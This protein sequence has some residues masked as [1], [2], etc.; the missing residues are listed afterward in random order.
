METLQR[1]VGVVVESMQTT[2]GPDA[3]LARPAGS[4]RVEGNPLLAALRQM[5]QSTIAERI[6]ALEKRLDERLPEEASRVTREALERLEKRVD[7][8]VTTLRHLTDEIGRRQH[9]ERTAPV[10]V[11]TLDERSTKM[12]ALTALVDELRRKKK[13]WL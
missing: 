8:L 4:P 7:D 1:A 9:E 2:S 10:E 5:M 13:G 3:P 6:G 11:T 12:N